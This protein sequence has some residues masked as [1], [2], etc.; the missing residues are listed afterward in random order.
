[1]NPEA[2]NATKQL[3]K[4]GARREET[5]SDRVMNSLFN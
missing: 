3:F 2:N 4:L 5:I 1:M